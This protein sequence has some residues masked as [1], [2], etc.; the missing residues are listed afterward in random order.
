[1]KKKSGG[2]KK[3]WDGAEK[4]GGEEGGGWVD[5]GTNGWTERRGLESKKANYPAR[6]LGRTRRG[7]DASY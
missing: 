6:L 1:M 4:K 7:S 5:G 2:E 3:R